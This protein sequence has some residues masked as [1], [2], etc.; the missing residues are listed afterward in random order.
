MSI[1]GIMPGKLS[2]EGL[3]TLNPSVCASDLLSATMLGL[4][5]GPLAVSAAQSPAV[6]HSASAAGAKAREP[7]P[8]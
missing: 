6:A 4:L 2:D 3:C 8:A 7:A 5:S 1:S